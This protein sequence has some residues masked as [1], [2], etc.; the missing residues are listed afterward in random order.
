MTRA[1]DWPGP[2]PIDL[3][4][5]DLPHRSSATEWWYLNT[6]VE[7]E[8]GRAL[9]LFAAFFRILRGKDERTGELRHAHSLTWAVSDPASR[10][11]LAE[12]RVDAEAPRIGLERIESGRGSRDPRLNRAVREILEKGR[13]PEP[14]RMFDGPVRVSEERLQL[15]FAGARLDK[16]DDGRY[17][18]E[19]ASERGGCALTFAPQKPPHRHG[20]DGVVRGLS[21]E[22]MFYYFIPRC[23]VEGTLTI[24]GAERRI[25]RRQGWYDH[26][27]GGFIPEGEKTGRAREQP[28]KEDERVDIAWNWVSAQL[29]GGVD[30]SAYSLQRVADGKILHEWAVMSGPD[31]QQR[32]FTRMSLDAVEGWRSTRT[33][34]DYP[35]KWRLQI[36]EARLD[37]TVEAAFAD[38]EFITCISKP[39]FWEGRVSVGGT[40]D[41]KA[42]RGLGYVERSGFEPIKTLDEFFAACGEEVRRSVAHWVP[43]RPTAK[44]ARDLVGGPGREHYLDGMDLDQLGSALIDPIRDITDRGGKSWRSY[45][46]LACCDVV[47]GDSRKFV[48][49]LAMPELMHVGSLIVDDVQDRSTLRRGGPTAHLIHG[50]PLA[51]NAGTAAYFIMQRLLDTRDITPERRLAIYDL[52]FEAMRAGHAGQAIDLDG[53]HAAMPAVVESGD[54]RALERRVLTTYRLKAGAPAGC[55]A[56]MGAVAGGGEQTQIDAVGQFFETLGV[57][58]QVIDDVLNL[59][60]FKGELKSR[61]EDVR[62]GTITLPVVRAMGLLPLDERRAL[63]ATLKAKPTDERVV[64][65]TVERLETSGA[66]EACARLAKGLVEESWRLT[67]PHLRDSIYKIML[68]AF[69]WYL[70]ERHY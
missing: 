47:Q 28:K 18:L 17:R 10:V 35:T 53:M 34:Y 2:G 69:G 40:V 15:D 27:F 7:T 60:G 63:W 54:G 6:H 61:G 14:D 5:H 59:R 67:E 24:D 70:L 26:E 12:S 65:A 44:E 37:L 56:R 55:L 38:Q 64:A 46:A 3:R 23:T 68:R 66:V 58:F 39:A 50:E 45:A 31:G 51:I 41:G 25:A 4:V 1:Q 48:R 30:V 11:Y 20:D 49:W 33:F 22:A 32:S 29:D 62:N 43:R 36:P 21:G 8:D 42:V 9:S 16:L 57:A 52:Y 19:L 13:V